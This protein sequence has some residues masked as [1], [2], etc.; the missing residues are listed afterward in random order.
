MD[1]DK[2]SHGVSGIMAACHM[3][4]M[5]PLLLHHFYIR[6]VKVQAAC[7]AV[8]NAALQHV[9]LMTELI[10]FIYKDKND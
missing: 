10:Q 3:M 5:W 1:Q 6:H 4:G 9:H 7:T 8:Q 2:S